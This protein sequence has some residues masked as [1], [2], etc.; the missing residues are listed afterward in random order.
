MMLGPLRKGSLSTADLK[1]VQARREWPVRVTQ[2]LQ[3]LAQDRLIHPASANDITAGY[4]RTY[5]LAACK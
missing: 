1:K 4:S 2:R 3:I 5:L